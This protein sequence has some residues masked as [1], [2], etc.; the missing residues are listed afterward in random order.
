MAGQRFNSGLVRNW[1]QPINPLPA[2]PLTSTGY[3]CPNVQIITAAGATTWNSQVADRSV[4]GFFAVTTPVTITAASI[5]VTLSAVGGELRTGIYTCNSVGLPVDL[6]E[7]FG[8]FD[9]SSTGKKE[10]T[11]LSTLLQPGFYYSCLVANANLSVERQSGSCPYWSNH[12]IT[13][14]NPETGLTRVE[15]YGALPAVASTSGGGL[16]NGSGGI[17]VPVVYKFV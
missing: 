10:L 8:V 1:G 12:P 16:Q 17:G 2:Q 13:S 5:R 7:D 3:G 11:G 15:T 6:V 4:Y 9:A 14:S